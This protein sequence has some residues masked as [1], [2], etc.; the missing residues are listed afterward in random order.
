[1]RKTGLL[2]L[3][4]VVAVVATWAA[5]GQAQGRGPTV[6]EPPA[7]CAMVCQPAG[8]GGAGCPEC[9]RFV[10]EDGDGVCDMAAACGR[11]AERGGCRARRGRC[12][13]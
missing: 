5:Y 12:G 6:A 10:D 11:G 1:M 8:C 3:A 9:P 2:L 13:R 7:G 4:V